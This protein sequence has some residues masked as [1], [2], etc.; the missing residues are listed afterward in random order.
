MASPNQWQSVLTLVEAGEGVALV[1]ACVQ[2]L[3]SPGVIFRAL[4]HPSLLVD[5]ILAW[6]RSAPDVI[7]DGF[8]DLL[9]K[10]RPVT[11]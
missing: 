8:L 2:Q 5:V 11:K 10:N 7:R 3:R 4:H 6:R 9:R 1:P